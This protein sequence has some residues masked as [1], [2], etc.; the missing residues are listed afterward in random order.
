MSNDEFD[1]T[2]LNGTTIKRNPADLEKSEMCL[3][4]R[5]DPINKMMGK[6]Y[7]HKLTALYID[8]F[9]KRDNQSDR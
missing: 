4:K 8:S 2:N 9:V 7:R 5:R 3:L 6:R 1:Y